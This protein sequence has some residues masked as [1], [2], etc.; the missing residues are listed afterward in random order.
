LCFEIGAFDSV[1]AL[2]AGTT[3]TT[4][5]RQNH[6]GEMVVKS[7]ATFMWRTRKYS[8]NYNNHLNIKSHIQDKDISRL[9]YTASF[10]TAVLEFEDQTRSFLTDFPSVDGWSFRHWCAR[11]GGQTRPLWRS[12]EIFLGATL[13]LLMGCLSALLC[14]NRRSS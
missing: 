2:F 1:S 7:Y 8:Y 13:H 10:G 4:N 11:I 12:N 6:Q 5:E 3:T 14:S 9:M